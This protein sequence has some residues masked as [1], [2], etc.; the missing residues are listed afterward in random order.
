MPA[1]VL[2][3]PGALA[4]KTTLAA[5]LAQRIKTQ[6][7]SVAL[8]RLA[9]GDN[10]EADS[11]FFGRLGGTQEPSNA[12]I[13]LMEAPA[14]DASAPLAAVGDARALVIADGSHPVE[15]IAQYC[16]TL[17]SA[18]AGLIIN[19]APQRRIS[20]LS[21]SLEAAGVKPLALLPEDR[22]LA[23]PTLGEVAL[24]LEAQTSFFDSNGSRTL[25]RT[26]VASISADPGQGYFA[27]TQANT[28]IVRSD[29][30]DLQ[31]AAINAGAG[32][33]I[34]TGGLPLLGY[35]LERAEEDEIPILRTQLDTIQTVQ[36]I[37]ALYGATPFSGGESRL[38]R[39]EE[40]LSE[41]DISTLTAA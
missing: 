39:L 33:L 26:L 24:A 40:L 15:E 20:A 3:S 7:R 14:G 32:C 41:I 10:A 6:G 1:L 8:L 17:G 12:D 21:A 27:S 37:E 29:K 2:V 13:V 30:P 18:F 9:G 28:V 25:D 22:I 11:G 35:V 4:G 19:R 38:R 16:Q 5:A 31:L 23:A 34:V 36:S